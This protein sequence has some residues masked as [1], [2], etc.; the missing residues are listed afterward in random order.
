MHQFGP[1]AVCWFD[2][3]HLISL[4]KP[5][6]AIG[7]RQV[8]STDNHCD[9]GTGVAVCFQ[10]TWHRTLAECV[11]IRN[12]KNLATKPFQCVA[13]RSSG[14][15]GVR[16]WRE[17]NITVDVI[18][19]Y[20]FFNLMTAVPGAEYEPPDAFRGQ[21]LQQEIEEHSASDGCQ[22]FGTIGHRFA[23][24]RPKAST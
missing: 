8:A 1:R 2:R 16:L 15:Q 22:C 4:A 7:A 5:N 21:L 23:E 10:Q 6:T 17:F 18:L 13:D 11:S 9:K 20:V 12:D 14:A 19:L 24:T 3:K